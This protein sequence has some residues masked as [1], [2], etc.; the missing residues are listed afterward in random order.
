M[1]EKEVFRFETINNLLN[2]K[3]AIGEAMK[4][5]DLSKRQI[6]RLRKRVRECGTEGIIH[7]GRGERSNRKMSEEI[8]EKTAELLKEKYSDFGPTFA[9]EKLLEVHDML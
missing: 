3:L 5:L 9:A 8:E 6:K 2:K 1:T 4:L 7:Q